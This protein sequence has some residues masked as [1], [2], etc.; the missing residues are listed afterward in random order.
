MAIEHILSDAD[1]IQGLAVKYNVPWQIIVDY[2]GLE[3]PYTLTS[4]EAYKKLYASGYLTVVRELH[5]SALTFYKGSSF[6][7]ELD[8]QGIQKTYEVVEDTTIPAG[9]ATGYLFVRCTI[10]GTFGNAVPESIILPGKVTTNLGNYV[11]ALTVTNQQAFANGTDA[12]VRTTGQSVLIPTQGAS[13]VTMNRDAYLL[14][15]GGEDLAL[16]AD[17]DLLDDEYGDLETAVGIENVKQSVNHRLMTRRGSLTQHPD[18][19]SR[20]HELIGR[21]QAPYIQNMIELDIHETLLQDDRISEVAVNTVVIQGT[22]VYMD[23]HITVGRATTS[24]QTTVG[25]V[26]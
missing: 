4:Q 15:L 6:V 8:A 7:T 12:T 23:L 20:L 22:S 13:E 5:S 9:V 25:L 21:A 2:N 19:G 26:A 14:T 24:I 17:G 3:Y 1:T 18:Y 11:S 10:Y 16:G